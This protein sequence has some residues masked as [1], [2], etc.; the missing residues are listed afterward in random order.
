MDG[1]DDK[2]EGLY[3]ASGDLK[4]RYDRLDLATGKRTFVR[5]ITP[6]D[7]T[8]VASLA[9]VRLTPDGKAYCYSFMRALS[10]LYVIDGLR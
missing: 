5:E 10:R 1:W 8:G 4:M 2:G 7:P 6:A 3:L 9:D